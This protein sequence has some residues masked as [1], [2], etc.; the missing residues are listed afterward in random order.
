MDK[1]EQW[2]LE[3]NC[4]LCRR[5]NYCK[6]ACTRHKRTTE[7]MIRSMIGTEFDRMTGG[8]FSKILERGE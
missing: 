3:G 2:N 5:K 7:G 4:S 1:S 6:K 8:A